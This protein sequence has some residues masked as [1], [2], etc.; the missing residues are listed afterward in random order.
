MKIKYYVGREDVPKLCEWP[1]VEVS[2]PWGLERDRTQIGA[3]N[4]SLMPGKVSLVTPNLM[5]GDIEGEKS[6]LP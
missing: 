4:S 6:F 3:E 5:D 1:F 2:E